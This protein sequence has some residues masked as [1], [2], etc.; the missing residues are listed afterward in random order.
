[1]FMPFIKSPNLVCRKHNI[2]HGSNQTN[3][4]DPFVTINFTIIFGIWIIRNIWP[5][6]M[7]AKFLQLN[8]NYVLQ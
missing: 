6:N 1:M 7:A 4:D 2:L 3:V 5:T 8:M